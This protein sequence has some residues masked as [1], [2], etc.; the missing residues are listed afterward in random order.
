LKNVLIITYSFP[1]NPAIGGVRLF[2]LAKYLPLYG[3]NPIILTPVLPGKPDPGMCII[4]TPYD[5]VVERW[6][7]RFGFDPKKTLN[8]Q[9]QVKRK[10]DQPSFINQLTYLP[11]EIITYPDERIGWYDHAVRAGERILKT[12]TIDAILSSSRPETCHLIAKT[13]AVNYHIPWVADFRDLWSQNHYSLNSRL[14]NYFIRN[15][16]I[17]TLKSASAITTVSQPLLERLAELHKNKQIFTVKNGFD[18]ESLNPENSQVDQY[19]TIV[20][21]GDLYEGKR[22]PTRLFTAI[23]ELCEE[24]LIKRDDIRI[25]FFGY[26]KFQSESW[27]EEEIAKYHIGDLVILHG[28]ISHENALSEQRKAQILLLLMWN[29]PDERGVYTGKLFEYLAARRPIIS[30]GLT[31][32]GVVKELLD[33]THAGI[34]AGSYDE[35]KAAILRSYREYKLSGA[36]QYRGI[37]SEVLLYSQQEMAKNFGRVLDSVIT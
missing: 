18:P 4:Q 33:Q 6:K 1:P 29:N 27:L 32:G 9:L 26:P 14:K 7:R 31:E 22:D 5:D 19:F 23:H 8:T 25:H 24:D 16:E 30:Y 37:N 10:K 36:V 11:N 20:Y 12:T 17:K 13:L 21:T 3:W 2:G 15:L 28:K 34:H 35:L